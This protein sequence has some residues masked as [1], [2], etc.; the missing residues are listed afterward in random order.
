MLTFTGCGLNFA[1]GV[2]Q[3]LYETLDGPFAGASPA[4]IDL[5][6]T[7]SVSLMTM[8][9]PFASSWTKQYGPRSVT[10]C[11]GVLF[12]AANVAASFGRELWHFV[13]AQGLLLGCATCLT[14]IPSVT[15]APG[16][17]DGRR[18]LAMGIILSGT[19]L[20]G[21]AWAPLLRFLNASIGFRTT[22]RV[23]GVIAFVLITASALVLKW[24]PATDTQRLQQAQ[25]SR[26]RAMVHFP[27]ANWAIVRSRAFAAH[28]S[29]AV[30]QAAAY[31]TPVYFFSSYAK[32]LGYSDAA[33]ANFIA[34]SNAMNFSGK[35]VI[36]YLADRY[37]RINA[38]VL[39]TLISALVTFGLWLPSSTLL[40]ENARRGL[41]VAFA[42]LY[43]LSA[44]AY[45]ALFPT[46]LA[47]QF[48]I[49]NFASINGLLYMIRGIGTLVGTPIAGSLIHSQPVA[50]M[51]AV[52]SFEKT[53]LMVGV[54]LLGATIAVTWARVEDSVRTG[55]KWRA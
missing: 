35:I 30:L 18:G 46:A 2:Y 37:G 11:G 39:C 54:L 26:S 1:F 6:G 42:C 55:W 48:G 50:L 53:I 19:G 21:V 31:Y 32:T 25:S 13:L 24:E 5:I 38:L 45:V 17:F 12:L 8:G 9:A 4:E 43:G 15:V 49:Q 44:S 16:W 33:G 52:V 41:F 34:L 23:T 14:Y 10:L 28:A 36:G 51:D 20:G 7:L 27:R 3:E 47:E 22:L 29:A 40:E